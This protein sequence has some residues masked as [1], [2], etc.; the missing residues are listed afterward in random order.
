MNGLPTANVAPDELPLLTEV[1]EGG[2]LDDLPTLTEIIPET[3][4]ASGPTESMA[5]SGT[6][7]PATISPAMDLPARSGTVT[8]TD[9][10]ASVETPA[11]LCISEDA[12]LAALQQRIEAHLEAVFMDRLAQLQQQAAEQ[13]LAELKAALPDL[14]QE[15]LNTTDSS[16]MD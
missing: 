12:L 16:G 11:E 1:A 7:I 3:G 5:A 14:L 8:D 15:A 9:T 2:Q 13:A 10:A 6:S 4:E